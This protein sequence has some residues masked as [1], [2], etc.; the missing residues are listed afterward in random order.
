MGDIMLE[1]NIPCYYNPKTGK[2][3]TSKDKLYPA[4]CEDPDFHLCQDLDVR[5]VDDMEKVVNT[6]IRLPEKTSLD[7][8]NNS[9]NIAKGTVINARSGFSIRVNERWATVS[10]GNF[11]DLSASQEAQDMADALTALLRNACG[12]QRNVADSTPEYHRWTENIEK[13]LKKLGI[14]TSKDFTVNG[15]KYYKDNQGIIRSEE[16]II[17]KKAYEQ[18]EAAYWEY[19]NAPVRS[20][21]KNYIRDYYL[22]TVPDSVK[23]AWK[24][25][26]E[27]TGIDPFQGIYTSVF[28]RMA[29]EQ[30]MDTGGNY[31]ILGNTVSSCQEAIQSVL[32]RID[33]MLDRAWDDEF[34]QREKTFYSAVLKNM[35]A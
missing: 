13:V 8:S 16:T 28:Q 34:L 18:R 19:R 29:V 24:K 17:A 6:D 10:G 11:D 1:G 35:Q 14:D 12:L 15:T 26:Q 2:L 32:E 31:N 4:V 3:V 25:T 23:E 21:G 5:P 33:L 9:I 7:K 30:E 20:N 22:K 27:E